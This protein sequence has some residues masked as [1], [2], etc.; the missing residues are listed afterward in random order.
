M[1]A[2]GFECDAMMVKVMLLMIILIIHI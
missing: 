1:L 2:F